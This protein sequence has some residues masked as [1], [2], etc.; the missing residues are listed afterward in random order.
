MAVRLSIGAR[1]GRIIRQ[2]LTESLLLALVGTGFGIVL[3]FWG[4]DLLARFYTV[5]GERFNRSYDLSFDW[6]VILFSVLLAGASALLFG[7]APALTACRQDLVTTLKE[8]GGSVGAQRHRWL[9][10]SL[11]CAQVALSLLLLVSAG[12]LVRSSRTVERGTNFDPRHVVLMRLRPELLHFT[13]AQ[14]EAYFRQVMQRLEAAAGVQSV[15]MIQGGQ[16]L[17]WE[18]ESG[19]GVQVR[20]PGQPQLPD[21]NEIL[22]HDVSPRFFE[23]LKIPLLQG[24]G[25]TDQEDATAPRAAIVNQTLANRLWPRESAVEHT[26]V[27]SGQ[28]MRVVGVAADIQPGSSVQAPAPYVYLPFWQS[29]PGKNGDVRLAIR[30]TDDPVAELPKLRAVVR[31]LDANIPLGEDMAMTEQVSVTYM[32]VLLA[33]TIMA[34]CGLLALCLS[35]VGLYSVL[36]FTIRTRTREIGL[37]LALGARPQQVVRLVLREGLRVGAVGLAA[38]ILAAI[39]TTRLLASWLYG[40]HS[41]D[42]WSFTAAALL[43]LAAAL[44]ASYLPSRRASRVDPMVALRYE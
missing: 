36:A 13:P 1:R 21:A 20:L 22:H 24:R 12:L 33:R 8:G 41:L 14:N 15:T 40:V 23:T 27:I 11:V 26:V 28:T 42:I 25:F 31:A 16:G 32:P 35:A 2:L 34:Y 4:R 43:L 10:Q 30:V 38:G 5:N 19:R 39:V 37:R 7:L 17:V 44:L 6:R 3:S 18:W 29:N 9:R